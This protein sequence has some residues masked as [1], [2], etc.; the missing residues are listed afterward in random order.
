MPNSTAILNQFTPLFHHVLANFSIAPHHA[1]YDDLLQ[2]LRLKALKVAASFD[3]DLLDQDRF[4]F[5]AYLKRALSWYCLD[6]LR[7]KPQ[8]TSSLEG[9][10]YLRDEAPRQHSL[11]V[12][13]FLSQAKTILTP[14]EFQTVRQLQAG[15]SLTSIAETDGVSRQAVHCRVKRL[16]EKLLPLADILRP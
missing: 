1:D 10:H 15:H 7:R 5:T 2:E 9:L 6:L 16:R 13:V 8:D 4:R 14:K 3:G 11:A 12:Q